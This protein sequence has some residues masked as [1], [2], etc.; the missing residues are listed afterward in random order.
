MSLVAHFK[1]ST[2]QS[3]ASEKEKVEMKNIPYSSAVC[4]LMYA[5]ICNRPDIAY[6]VGVVSQFLTSPGKEHWLGVKWILGY[7]R[8]ISKK[9]MCFVSR[10]KSFTFDQ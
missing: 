2:M 10:I 1:L 8:G 3:P 5:M 6:S 7:L 4:S 9:C